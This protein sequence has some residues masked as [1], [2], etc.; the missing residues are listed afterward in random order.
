MWLS[1]FSGIWS[2]ICHFGLFL[3]RL[4]E[5]PPPREDLVPENA[6]DRLISGSASQSIR[7]ATRCTEARLAVLRHAWGREKK[8]KSKKN[9]IPSTIFCSSLQTS[10]ILAKQGKPLVVR[11]IY[12]HRDQ[13]ER[14]GEHVYQPGVSPL[15]CAAST[16]SAGCCRVISQPRWKRRKAVG[17]PTSEARG[18]LPSLYLLVPLRKW[19]FFSG[20]MLTVHQT[21]NSSTN[22]PSTAAGRPKTTRWRV[23]RSCDGAACC[24][25]SKQEASPA[26]RT[27]FS[28]LERRAQTPW[29]CSASAPGADSCCIITLGVKCARQGFE[30][31]SMENPSGK[32]V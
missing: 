13:A 26:F 9:P 16:L 24:S 7:K 19:I 29:A 5:P 12:Q 27:R 4:I 15:S 25:Q 10:D 22:T 17:H 8:N 30:A 18:N 3:D 2:E 28:A 11:G 20:H 32:Y 1:S 23:N 31:T 14:R 6:R 21:T